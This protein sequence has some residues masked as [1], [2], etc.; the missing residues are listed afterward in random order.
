MNKYKLQINYAVHPGLTLKEKLEELQLTPEEFAIRTNI[1]IKTI[2][3]ILNGILNEK[4]SITPKIAAKFEKV[5]NIPATF[6]LAK[7]SNYTRTTP[8]PPT[9]P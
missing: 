6:W 9:N 7:Q 1:P 4:S 8:T 2:S 3:S 5:L